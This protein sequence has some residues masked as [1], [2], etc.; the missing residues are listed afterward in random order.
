MIRW[1]TVYYNA[2]AY[3]IITL[4]DRLYTGSKK[5]QKC[6]RCT[7]RIRGS[8]VSLALWQVGSE[9]L[10]ATAESVDGISLSAAAAAAAALPLP[11]PPLP[12]GCGRA[13]LRGAGAAPLPTCPHCPCQPAK[14]S[15]EYYRLLTSD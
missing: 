9:T 14:P 7:R 10:Q 11:P 6:P 8:S 15:R 12:A 2:A 5:M 3:C 4:V 1:L 13:G